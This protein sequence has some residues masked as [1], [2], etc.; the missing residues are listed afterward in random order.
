IGDDGPEY[1]KL[2]K[3]TWKYSDRYD[4]QGKALASPVA[5]QKTYYSNGKDDDG[6]ATGPYNGIFDFAFVGIYKIDIEV[7]NNGNS[8]YEQ[9][10][11]A[12]LEE[13]TGQIVQKD[14]AHVASG[15]AEIVPAAAI[16]SLSSEDRHAYYNDGNVLLSADPAAVFHGIGIGADAGYKGQTIDNVKYPGLSVED[17]YEVINKSELTFTYYTDASYT[18]VIAR[19]NIRNAGVYYVRVTHNADNNKY[20]DSTF[21][22]E[23]VVSPAQYMLELVN[24]GSDDEVYETDFGVEFDLSKAK[25]SH[26]ITSLGMGKNSQFENNIDSWIQTVGTGES[27]YEGYTSNAGTYTIYYGWQWASNVSAAVRN[28][29]MLF[30]VSSRDNKTSIRV[31]PVQLVE[32][33]NSKVQVT[34][35]SSGAYSVAMTS[36]S[37]EQIIKQGL[38]MSMNYYNASGAVIAGEKYD[39]NNYSFTY[40]WSLTGAEGTYMSVSGISAVGKYRLA[41]TID[42]ANIKGCDFVIPFEV[43]K[44]EAYFKLNYEGSK[45]YDGRVWTLPYGIYTLNGEVEIN[46]TD[47]FE[48]DSINILYEKHVGASRM[49]VDGGIVDAGTYTVRISGAETEDYAA[50]RE[51][52]GSFVVEKANVEISYVSDY[53]NQRPYNGQYKVDAGEIAAL[54][55]NGERYTASA[56]SKFVTYLSNPAW[57]ENSGADVT[58]AVNAYAAYVATGGQSYF[59]DWIKV[60]YPGVS[61]YSNSDGISDVGIYYPVAIYGGD[62][63]VNYSIA[64]AAGTYVPYIE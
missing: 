11:E 53:V 50:I 8:C 46:I 26:K 21:L 52:I 17:G 31:N 35:A 39:L 23:F 6:Q 58:A 1:Q 28:N 29:I 59:P 56:E 36:V 64:P 20:Q 9:A 30:D 32:G 4:A 18:T 41:V 22:F 51:E 15:T 10:K 5:P 27:T 55:L 34:G 60:T 62:D 13:S 37:W 47:L 45:V 19:N 38:N 43:T 57:T 54:M 24:S 7:D 63:N 49:P 44:A 2:Y 42:D 16:F 3:W 12:V 61:V 25:I 40:E 14:V 33:Q 48:A